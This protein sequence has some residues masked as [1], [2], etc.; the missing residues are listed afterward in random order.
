[1]TLFST[2]RGKPVDLGFGGFAHVRRGIA[3]R[4]ARGPYRAAALE[5]LTRG[6]QAALAGRRP[7][8]GGRGAWLDLSRPRL[9]WDTY[10]RRL[11]A[12]AAAGAV[13]RRALNAIYAHAVPAEVQLDAQFHRWRFNIAVPEPDRL[14]RRL[15][16]AGLFAGRH[17]ASLGGVVGSGRFPEAEALHARVVNLFTDGHYDSAMA[18]RTAD[19]VREHLEATA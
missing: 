12:A 10:R 13:H 11:A 1:M 19:L 8:R 5:R 18:S 6:Y 9:G 4:R 16:A 17:Y 7:F 2:G 14:V 3:Y 15:L